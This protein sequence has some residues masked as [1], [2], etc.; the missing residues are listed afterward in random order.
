MTALPTSHHWCLFLDVDGT[1]LD[2]AATP[3]GV[4]VDESLHEILLRTRIVL[5]GAM[6]LISGRSLAQLDRM[7]SPTVWPAAG[8][9]GLERRDAAG[10]T[11]L[12]LTDESVLDDAR[13]ALAA[14]TAAAP[15][16]ILEDKGLALALHYRLAPGLEQHLRRE[17]GAIARRLGPGY[18]V[19]EGSRVLELKP[20]A[21]TKADAIRAFMAE[22]PFAGHRPVFVGDDLTDLDGFAAVERLGGLSVAVG[23]RVNAM[24]RVSSPRD[25]RALLE[26]LAEDKVDC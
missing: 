14:I 7:F 1:L 5:Q 23:D 17:I 2:F 20:A 18:H 26:D 25:V 10:H 21:A 12:A 6:A 19:Q 4:R 15:G 8:L 22:E 3:D 16:V 24:S 11:H 9:H 13:L